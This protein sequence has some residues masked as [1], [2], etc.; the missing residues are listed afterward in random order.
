M[1]VGIVVVVDGGIILDPA[2][3]AR[4]VLLGLVDDDDAIIVVIV[5]VVVVTIAVRG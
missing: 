4:V 1:V 3:F 2:P 5:V